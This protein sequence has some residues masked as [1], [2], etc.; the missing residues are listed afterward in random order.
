[1]INP[2]GNI[3]P[4]SERRWSEPR[5]EEEKQPP[6]PY[7]PVKFNQILNFMRKTWTENYQ[8][9]QPTS[10]EQESSIQ[11]SLPTSG[12][13]ILKKFYFEDK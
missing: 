7:V 10:H 6:H 3:H 9:H 13:L 11:T 2:I 1:M 4:Q 5:T 12:N 8:Q